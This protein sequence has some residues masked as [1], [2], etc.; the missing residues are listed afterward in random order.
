MKGKSTAQLSFRFFWDHWNG[1]RINRLEYYLSALERYER[2]AARFGLS[3][4]FTRYVNQNFG[5]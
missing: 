5:G 4:N 1:K 2:N 3:L